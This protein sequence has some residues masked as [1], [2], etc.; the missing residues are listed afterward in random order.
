MLLPR[1]S[2]SPTMLLT[3]LA[4]LV[5]TSFP[6]PASAAAVSRARRASA[7]L[8]QDEVTLAQESVAGAHRVHTGSWL[9]DIMNQHAASDGGSEEITAQDGMLDEG[10]KTTTDDGNKDENGEG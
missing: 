9:F 3:A 10:E 4:L 2:L 8:E 7:D 5:L 6:S 1:S